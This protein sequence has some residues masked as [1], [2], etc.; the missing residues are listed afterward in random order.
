MVLLCA[1]YV[2]GCAFRSV[3]PR[4][5]VQR[6]SLFDTWLSSVLV[7]R[8]VA[9]IAELCFVLQWALVLHQLAHMAKADTARNIAKV[10]VPLILLAELCSWYAVI[11]TNYLGNTL[12]NSLWA[13]TFLL[14]AAALLRL[15]NDFRGPVRL[16]LGLAVAGITV[17][18][19][20]LV[21]VDVPMYFARWQADAA[22]GKE[23][24]GVLAGL[25]D[26]GTRWTV[27]HDI[28]QWKDEIAWMSLYFSLAVWSSLALGGFGLVKHRLPQYRLRP[29][30]ASMASRR[31]SPPVVRERRPAPAPR[32]H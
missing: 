4:A 11:T 17:Y 28:T 24:F 29:A 30:S 10:I 15:M 21:R 25:H 8:S 6:I 7:G 20:F 3:L 26:L 5:D 16:A 22:N 13:V 23:L 18:L 19:V 31:R 9:T 14:I 1:A 32:T 12:E 2:F 27:T